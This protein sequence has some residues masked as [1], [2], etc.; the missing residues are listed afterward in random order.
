MKRFSL[1]SALPALALALAGCGGS[2]PAAADKPPFQ[3]FAEIDG[4]AIL[5]HTKTLSSDAFEGRAPGSKGEDFTV[6]YIA[7]QFRKA[8]LKPGNTD[9]T[10]TQ[11]VPLIGIT[12]DPNV[13]LT[14]KK[15][16][17]E[18]RFMR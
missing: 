7:D 11:K 17:R 14:F 1:A 8:G 6:A 15:G 9:G 10:F 2:K 3:V 12:A 13:T 16:G 4:N 5:E 18:E